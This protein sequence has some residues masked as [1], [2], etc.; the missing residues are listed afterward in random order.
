MSN[1]QKILRSS[2]IK[3]Q[4]HD[5]MLRK[6]KVSADTIRKRKEAVRLDTINIYAADHT[7]EKPLHPWMDQKRI[8]SLVS[9]YNEIRNKNRFNRKI[10]PK[11]LPEVK[12]ESK[13]YFEYYVSTFEMKN[14]TNS[15]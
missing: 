5:L 3:S 9:V 8:R 11:A 2:S 6:P 12:K 4:V 7:G 1:L 10:D 14:L 15:I 13:E